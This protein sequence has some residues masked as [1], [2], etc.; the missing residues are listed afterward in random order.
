MG[1]EAGKHDSAE[2][3]TFLVCCCD[4]MCNTQRQHEEGGLDCHSLSVSGD[5]STMAGK[6]GC[7]ECAT[8]TS[9]AQGR[10]IRALVL[11]L[12]FPFH[13]V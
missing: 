6:S 9:L 11:Y 8:V 5:T 3:V 10:E 12:R 2:L 7:Q 4:Q 13:P 1:S